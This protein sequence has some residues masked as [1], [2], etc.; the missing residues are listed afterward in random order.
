MFYP[1]NV[2]HYTVSVDV[3]ELRRSTSKLVAPILSTYLFLK[4]LTK[5]DELPSR[6]LAGDV[7]FT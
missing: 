3:I 4:L 6:A 2:L 7:S 1:T 5:P